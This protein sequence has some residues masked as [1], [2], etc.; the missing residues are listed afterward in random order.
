MELRNW[1]R[2]ESSPVVANGIVYIGSDD[3]SVYA[4]N[5]D[6][7]GKLWSYPTG[8]AVVSSPAVANGESM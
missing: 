8:S 1:G 3:S 6:N 4:L 2:V 5:A 7:G